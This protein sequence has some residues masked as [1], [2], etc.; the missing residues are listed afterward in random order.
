MRSIF[1]E[2]GL[3]DRDAN[4]G[5]VLRRALPVCLVVTAALA[6]VG[7]AAGLAFYA[8][9]L[10]VPFT[11]AGA[12]TAYGD[13]IDADEGGAPRRAERVQA[14]CAT[15]AVGLLVLGAATR[16]PAVGEGAVPRFATT[17]LILCIA[18]LFV[19][20]AAAS[21]KQLREPLRAPADDDNVTSLDAFRAA[22]TTS[23]TERA[24]VS[25]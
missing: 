25:A 10:A 15:V 17:A 12:L 7:S 24:R 13:L 9:V 19:Q 4:L 14:I 5:V 23:E 18:V 11:A 6:D 2:T 8:L 16:A 3:S 22:A 20:L 21:A 1:G